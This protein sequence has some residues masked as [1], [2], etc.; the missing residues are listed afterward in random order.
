MGVEIVL[1]V[2]IAVSGTSGVEMVV[3][4]AGF[5]ARGEG[6]LGLSTVTVSE[7]L[8]EGLGVDLSFIRVDGDSLVAVQDSADDEDGSDKERGISPESSGGLSEV[9]TESDGSG[10]NGSGEL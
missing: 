10:D 1:V 6:H 9:V 4:E 3:V 7:E 5:H 8:V 2:T